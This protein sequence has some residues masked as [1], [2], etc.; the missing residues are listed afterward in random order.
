MDQLS[1]AGGKAVDEVTESVRSAQGRRAI[2]TGHPGCRTVTCGH[3]KQQVRWYQAV[4]RSDS[5]ADSST[6]PGATGQGRSSQGT[7]P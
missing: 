6:Y 2:T 4:N 5:Q 7:P 3:S 1:L